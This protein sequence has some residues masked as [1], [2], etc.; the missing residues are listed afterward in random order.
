MIG[1]AEL[2]NLLMRSCSHTEAKKHKLKEREKPYIKNSILKESG[3][4]GKHFVLYIT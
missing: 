1:K 3:F 2:F 4:V